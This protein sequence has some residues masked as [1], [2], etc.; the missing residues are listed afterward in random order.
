MP[1]LLA[2]VALLPFAQLANCQPTIS[3]PFNAQLPPAAR[4]DRFFS[5]SFSPYTFQSDSAISYSLGQHPDWLSIDSGGRRLYGTPK[6]GDVSPGQVVGQTFDIVATDSKGSTSMTAT[7]VIS[8]EPAPQV[9]IPLEKQIQNFGNFSAP[10]S[11]LS[12]P[13]TNFK[14]SFDQGTFGKPGLNY[15]AVS[16]DSS[17]LPAWVKFDAPAL[18]FTGRT[19][20]IE[21]LVQPPHTFDFSLVASDIVGFSAS[22]LKFSIVVGSHKLTTDH[23]IVTLNASRGGEVN[24]NG[25]ESG[26]KLDGKQIAAGDLKYTVKDMP[27][28][29]SFDDK[30]WKLQGTPK[31]GDHAANL[32]ITFM[33]SFSDNLDVLVVVNVATGLFQSTFEDMK[34]RPGSDFDLDLAKYFKD[35]SDIAVKVST[36]PN[37]DWLKVNDLKLSGQVPKTSKGSF[38][39]YIDASSKSSDLQEKEAVN[40]AF[41]APDGTTTT[42]TPV[43]ST[44][45]TTATAT[46]TDNVAPDDEQT[47][48]GH[49]STGEIL[50]ATIIPVIFVAILLM[51]LVCYFRRRRT[52]NTYMGSRYRSKISNPVLS[53]LRVN[54]SDQSMREAASMGGA[55]VQTETI[56]YKPAKAALADDNSP[57]ST[58][59]R[60]SETLGDLSNSASGMPH[61]MMVDAARTTTIRSV[62]NVPSEDGRQSWVTID[63][64]HGGMGRSDRSSRSHQSDVTYPDST[65][66]VFP[67]AD[68]SSHRRDATLDISLPTLD[69]LPSVQPN[70]PFAYNPHQSPLS[71]HSVGGLSAITSSSAALPHIDDDANYTTASM[72]KWNTGSTARDPS[73]PNWISLAESEAGESVSELRR[74]SPLALADSRP[75][76]SSS[77]KSV[78]TE[79]SFGSSENWRVIGR[80]SPTKTERSY[81]DLVDEAPFHPSRPSTAR[82]GAGQDLPGVASPELMPPPRW[83]ETRS[84]LASERLG[85]S[86][87]IISKMSGVSEGDAQMSGGRG[88]ETDDDWIREH[89]GKMS[90]GS[91]KVF[92]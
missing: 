41:L 68:Y 40:V 36:S 3:F 90:D 4:I 64:G 88:H 13:S 7:V 62:S 28:W 52:R 42:V 12:Y 47:Q 75:A 35:P 86:V 70:P 6:D 39:L 21:S 46:K 81:K 32:T 80:Q 37:E 10:S 48:P 67:G 49:L 1:S 50:L 44:T 87:S 60:S 24:Y 30:T 9:Q 23:P 14:F 45:T 71:Y 27:S 56:V 8:R 77:G 73:E 16:G 76:G 15:Y 2:V 43:S 59:R 19:P 55:F 79:A 29:L 31:D 11:I 61:S 38:K 65:R 58:R 20:P 57:M 74:P 78:A 33:D 82:N 25:L 17:P 54:G 51:I 92:L 66:Q 26:I 89:S 53:T 85:P 91:F 34:I 69:E 22:S 83:G 63:G 72:T 5:Y 84:P 18:T